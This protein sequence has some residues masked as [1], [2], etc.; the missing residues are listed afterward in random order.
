MEPGLNTV[1]Q[2]IAWKDVQKKRIECFL[3]NLKISKEK[4]KNVKNKNGDLVVS[5]PFFS[6]LPSSM[7]LECT[8]KSISS[9]ECNSESVSF[10]TLDL[11]GSSPRNI[12][13]LWICFRI[14]ILVTWSSFLLLFYFNI[15]SINSYKK[16]MFFVVYI[17]A[18]KIIICNCFTE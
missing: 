6:F 4:I 16:S 7:L 8:S 18:K 5:N 3:K 2:T 10:G 13:E 12:H 17:Y 15:N 14:C 11:S 1:A 9:L